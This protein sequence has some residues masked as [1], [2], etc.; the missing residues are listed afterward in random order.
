[1]QRFS[2]YVANRLPASQFLVEVSGLFP[3]SAINTLFRREI[4][5]ARLS[6]K[7]Q[8]AADSIDRMLA[9]D[10]VGYIDKALRASG[11]K[12]ND[13]DEI[14][15]DFLVKLLMGAFLKRWNG[16]APLDARFK[17]AVKNGISSLK[18]KKTRPALTDDISF[19]PAAVDLDMDS[20][21]IEGFR[22][23]VLRELGMDALRLLDHRLD[24]RDTKD[25]LG[26]RGFETSY[27]LKAAVR[28]LKQAH[29]AY[30]YTS[31]D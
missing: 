29:A 7:T 25:L 15:Q 24:G 28:S 9:L 6:A 31:A 26:S 13:L 19:I 16:E 23:Y 18:R 12:A 10:V 17:V 30:A 4:S 5:K 2:S 11:Y 21:F 22:L 27:R 20:G 8:R 3:K 14:V 1:M